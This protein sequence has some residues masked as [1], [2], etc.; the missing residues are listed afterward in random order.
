LEISQINSN[1]FVYKIQNIF[2]LRQK[3]YDIPF[4]K[5]KL[6]LKSLKSFHLFCAHSLCIL[7]WFSWSHA[8]FAYNNI[9]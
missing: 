1:T 6:I 3:K 7:Y 4:K 9:S 8:I 5:T 2:Q